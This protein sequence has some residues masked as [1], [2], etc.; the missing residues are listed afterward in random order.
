ML[1]REEY[2]E[3]AFF[4]RSLAER[5][6][7][8]VPTQDLLDSLG[9]EILATTNLPTAIEFMASVMRHSGGFAP[10]MEKLSHYFTPFQTYVVTEAE[11]D[12]SRFD[13]NV[14]VEVLHREASYRAEGPSPQGIFLF[15]FETICRNRLGYFKGLT[16]MAGDPVYDEAWRE[17]L[18]SIRAH[19]GVIDIADLLYLRSQHFA[20]RHALRAAGQAGEDP[21]LPPVLFGEKEGQIALANR[22]KDPLLLF[23]AL[24]RHLNYPLV[25]KPKRIDESKQVIPMLVR[26]MERL[27]G[28]LKLL[29]EESRG[30]I[31][32]TK[33]YK[34]EGGTMKEES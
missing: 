31:D 18:L 21:T 5:M 4:F 15:Q 29:E 30:G 27:E 3:Q 11:S 6:N 22:R 19:V 1:P 8:D 12:R 26:R 10:A 34:E 32:I 13:F 16:A 33:F 23:A 17:F 2:I 7:R 20:T 24:Q 9:Q 14:A 25:P 28:R